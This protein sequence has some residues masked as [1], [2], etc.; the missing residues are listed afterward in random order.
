MKCSWWFYSVH[1]ITD[2]GR[3][4]LNNDY[5]VYSVTAGGFIHHITDLG[6]QWLNNDY[7]V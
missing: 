4:W 5:E 6:R 7:E 1:H 3:K 2:L